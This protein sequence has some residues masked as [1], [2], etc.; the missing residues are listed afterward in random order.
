MWAGAEIAID[1]TRWYGRRLG[2]RTKVMVATRADD[3]TKVQYLYLRAIKLRM[4]DAPA[5]RATK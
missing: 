5:V 2:A 3:R 4:V 1:G